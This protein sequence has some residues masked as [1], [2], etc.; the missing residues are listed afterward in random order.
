M[1]ENIVIGSKKIDKYSSAFVI[2]ELSANH[3]Q[4]FDNAVKLI[5]EAKK[6]GADAVKLQTYTPDTITL[7]CDNQYFQIKQGT[8]WDGTTLYK[9]YQKAYTPWDWQ[10][11]LKRIA[12][13]EGLICFS[14][15]FD[16]SAV[17]FL[18]KMNVPAYKI[19]SFEITDIP[20]VEYVASKGKP[21]IMSTGIARLGDIQEALDACKKAGNNDVILLKCTSEYPSPLEDINL[22]TIP[23][24]H[25]TFGTLTGISDHT[26]G[27]TVSLGAVALGAKVVEK[28]FTLD[29]SEGGPDSAFSMEPEEFLQMVK[30]IR[31]MEKAL[32]RVNY[33]L[34]EKQIKS[35]EHSRSLFVVKDIK[36]GEVFTV[37]NVK[38]IRPGF[39]LETKYIDDVIGKRARCDIEKGTPL[40]WGLVE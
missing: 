16:R 39:G 10:P 35:R 28:H 24:M 11:R 21:V 4:N 26:L 3:L 31:D 14:S 13:E 32:G 22:K 33:E 29:R 40:K 34:T 17:D 18:E 7:D 25:D 23:N 36:A 38:S 5:K 30:G 1:N 2:A 19:A 37:D 9:L 15:P 6:A 12:E 27:Q 8:I 20:F